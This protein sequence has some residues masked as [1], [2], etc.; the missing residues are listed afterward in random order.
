[1]KTG[2]IGGDKGG[3]DTILFRAIMSVTVIRIEAWLERFKL[4]DLLKVRL[5]YYNRG[6]E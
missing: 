4:S 1:L 2:A 3:P 5:R 6:S